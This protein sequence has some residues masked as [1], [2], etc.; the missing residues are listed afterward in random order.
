MPKL[1]VFPKAYMKALCKDGTMKISE[2]ISLASKLNIQGLEWY[3]GFL[4]MEDKRRWKD[5]KKWLK[6][7]EKKFQ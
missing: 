7:L 6:I 4:E 1:A 2:W 5:F 3:A